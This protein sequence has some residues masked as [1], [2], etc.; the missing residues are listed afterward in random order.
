MFSLSPQV[1][2]P[3]SIQLDKLVTEM[4][5]YYEDEDNRELH[6]LE[7]VCGQSQTIE[8]QLHIVLIFTSL[9]L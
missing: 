4:T 8:S 1:V 9:V 3:R 2:G 7:K 5:E 6:L